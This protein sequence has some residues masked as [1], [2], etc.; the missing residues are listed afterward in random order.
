MNNSR[1]FLALKYAC[2]K[3]LFE[4]KTKKITQLN[5]QALFLV[6]Q[7]SF[8][9]SSFFFYKLELPIWNVA[10]K[11]IVYLVVLLNIIIFILQ[12]NVS[13]N[14]EDSYPEFLLEEE[15]DS[16]QKKQTF[17]TQLASINN[18]CSEVV[19]KKEKMLS[20]IKTGIL[21]QVVIFIGEE[22]ARICN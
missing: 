6:L 14:K 10:F 5:H 4:N 22:I 1:T 2:N 16:E 18:E 12:F 9:A 21:L 7:S 11:G 8:I 17:I 15:F 20:F 13:I 3:A 19:Q